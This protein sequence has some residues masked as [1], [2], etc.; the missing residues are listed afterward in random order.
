MATYHTRLGKHG[1]IVIPAQAR[2]AL[3]LQEGD[4]L[5]V[6]VNGNRIVLETEAALLERLYDA[7]GSRAEGQLPS[8]D[9]I[10]ERREEAKRER[11]KAG[12]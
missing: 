3:K 8:E 12:G 7:A 5:L 2:H 11:S 9:L 1:R 4:N 6:E 10:R